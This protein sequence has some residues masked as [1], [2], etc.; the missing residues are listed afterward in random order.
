MNVRPFLKNRKPFYKVP[1][2]PLWIFL[3]V[4]PLFATFCF[5]AQDAAHSGSRSMGIL[6][7][8]LRRFPS[9]YAFGSAAQL[10]RLL[11]KAAHFSLYFTLGCGLRGMYTY[12]RRFPAAPC[13][14]VA[15]GLCAALD[16]F[17]QHFSAGRAPSLTDVGIDTCGVMTGCLFVSLLF[18][19]F[20]ERLARTP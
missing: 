13:V 6:R 14:I 11:R 5:S 12:Q 8:L 18:L 7:A 10:H 4:L 9:L 3:T 1:P 19:L 17:H 15:G 16:E 2:L 20:R